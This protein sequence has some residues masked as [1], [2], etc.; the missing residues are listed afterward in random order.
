VLDHDLTREAGELTP[1][2]KLKRGFV[3]DRG[4]ATTPSR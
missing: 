2:Q 3:A 4:A 1:T